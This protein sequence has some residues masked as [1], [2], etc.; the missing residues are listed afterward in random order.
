MKNLAIVI[1]MVF[2]TNVSKA[3]SYQLEWSEFLYV[4]NVWLGS[5]SREIMPDL[6]GNTYLIADFGWYPE[7][8]NVGPINDMDYILI[9][10]D[11]LGNYLWHR[12]IATSSTICESIILEDTSFVYL[13]ASY[14]GTFTASN[15]TFTNQNS[16]GYGHDCLILKYDTNGNLLWGKTWHGN[17]HETIKSITQSI[18]GD[19]YCT[20]VTNS[21]SI[22]FESGTIYNDTLS[23]SFVLKLNQL[24]ELIW[25]CQIDSFLY[26]CNDIA[27]DTSNEVYLVT[28][29]YI[30]KLDTL[31]NEEWRNYYP[32]VNFERIEINSLNQ[33][34][35][36]GHFNVSS[37]SIGV[38]ELN[39][40]VG[41]IQNPP[42]FY[43]GNG[44]FF[45]M[46]I[47][48]DGNPIWIKD[49]Y[50][51]AKKNHK[52]CFDEDDNIVSFF[53]YQDTVIFD[54]VMLI[55]PN[56]D[57]IDGIVKYDV[58]GNL[59]SVDTLNLPFNVYHTFH[60]GKNNKLYVSNEVDQD[61]SIAL[62]ALK[63]SFNQKVSL[64]VGWSI[65]STYVYPFTNDIYNIFSNGLAQLELIKNNAGSVF[66]PQYN[67]FNIDSI[68]MGQAYQVKMNNSH[69]LY[70]HGELIIPDSVNIAY[71]AGW[72]MMA[73]LL[74]DEA[75]VNE[76]LSSIL[77]D[78]IIAKCD[79]GQIF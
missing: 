42:Y 31:G 24:G 37:V 61:Y 59:I 60:Y 40:N 35:I 29:E 58:H 66:W 16:L 19:L 2:A 44:E 48:Q 1:F 56:T 67:I 52:I 50:K 45:C 79:E 15:D 68:E 27:V 73:Y 30:I 10:F 78:V 5:S 11:N 33:I 71:P 72:N 64:S 46:R 8:P 75:T 65:I 7:I 20:G 17:K 54:S 49:Y 12:K 62:A 74:E 4:D 77:T 6:N 57:W 26:G 38:F 28:D 25:A 69:N 55:S 51:G 41:G 70:V 3:Q 21:D 47:N 9:K 18:E 63:Y 14:Y 36:T 22:P 13:A 34:F 39:Y 53:C 76:Y 23:V 32:D 43:Y